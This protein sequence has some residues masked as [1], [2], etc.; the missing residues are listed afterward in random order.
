MVRPLGVKETSASCYS[1]EYFLSEGDLRAFERFKKGGR[2]GAVYFKA[3]EHIPEDI[4]GPFLDI[5]CGRGEMV[6]HMARLGKRVYGIDYSPDAIRICQEVLRSERKSVQTLAGFRLVDCTNFPFKNHTFQCLFLL[7]LVEH[8]T[9][10]QLKLTLQE[11][12]RVLKS[13]G[14]LII[15][16]NNKYFEKITKITIAA[17]YHGIKVFLRPKKALEEESSSPY[18][19]LHINYLTGGELLR[20][21]EEVG[22]KAKI[23]YVKPRKKTELEKFVAY[24]EGWKKSIYFNAAWLLLNSSLIKF[25]SPTF[26]IIARKR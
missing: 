21:L 7:D 26:W 19:Y 16:T 2:P 22:F 11:A 13:Q 5:G 17:F 4:E 1:R 20:Y 18:E 10:R 3:L 15:H 24:P 14:V 6:V 9:P 23:E 12:N 8:L 25:I